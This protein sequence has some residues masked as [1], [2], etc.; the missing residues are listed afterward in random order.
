MGAGAMNAATAWTEIPKQM[1][2]ASAKHNP[3][4]GAT[5][6]LG[7]GVVKGMVRGASGVVDMATFGLPPY[8]KPLMQPAYEVKKPEEGFKVNLLNW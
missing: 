8:D 7:E 4:V 3:L 5:V 2:E 1:G 6:G